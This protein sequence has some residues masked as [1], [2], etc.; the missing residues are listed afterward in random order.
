MD[1]MHQ[2]TLEEWLSWKEDIRRK[3]S[4]AA[5]N[6]VYIGFRLK[7]IR[8]SGMLDG[9]ADIFE[10]AQKEFGLGKSTTSRFIAI[11]EKF[12]EGGNSLELRQEFKAISSS[13][14]AEMLTLTDSECQLIT[15]KTTVKEIR[16]LKSFSRQ[17]TPDG[18][19][20]GQRL[21]PLQK[22]LADF[23]RGKKEILNAAIPAIREEHYKDVAELI[24]PSGHCSHKKGICFLFMEDYSTGVKAKLLTD[25]VPLEMSWQ[26]MLREVYA[27]YADIY[28]NGE[29]DVHRA[30]YD[31]AIKPD[32]GRPE[33]LAREEDGSLENQEAG[34]A[35]ATSQQ[36]E[37][38]ADPEA[39]CIA[40][41]E[42]KD[43]MPCNPPEAAEEVGQT[44]SRAAAVRE[45]SGQES[46]Y[47]PL[48]GQME[49]GDYP[50]I[51]PEAHYEEIPLQEPGQEEN[52]KGETADGSETGF[53]KKS[54]G[55]ERP[56]V[57]MTQQAQD[58]EDAGSAGDTNAGNTGSVLIEGE[59][60]WMD[61]TRFLSD[62]S[63][64]SAIWD[65]E[66]VPDN[67]LER[68]YRTAIDVA[69]AIEKVM[70]MK[71]VKNG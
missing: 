50:G 70:N 40:E 37:K 4:E 39:A 24:N 44:E 41:N 67:M 63:Q 53:G 42:E 5:G 48:P 13:K 6:F 28:E 64:W 18:E 35:V 49:V 34:G 56:V 1:E 47:V 14:L 19:P 51:M 2:I 55:L 69:A 43:N 10:F 7:Q 21:S 33:S 27:I 15:E 16:E 20:D 8:D 29:K 60:A 38:E 25:P 11:N 65:Y 30:Y 52:V 31:S 66:T 59:L 61:I 3:L 57:E 36:K 45:P 71:G 62:L 9:A 26:E 12:S 46:E 23:F 22:C 32:K 68:A 58:P 17:Q 54:E